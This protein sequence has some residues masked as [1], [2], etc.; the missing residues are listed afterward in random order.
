MITNFDHAGGQGRYEFTVVADKNKRD[1]ESLSSA[2][3]IVPWSIAVG[4]VIP[5]REGRVVRR[6]DN[7]IYV[8]LFRRIVSPLSQN[9]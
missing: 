4:G 2:L 6:R 3:G 7:R 1:S 8:Q 5:L 9:I